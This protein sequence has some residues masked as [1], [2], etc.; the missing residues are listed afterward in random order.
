MVRFSY[1]SICKSPSWRPEEILKP[2]PIVTLS[3]F[4]LQKT[5][6]VVKH[7]MSKGSTP[8]GRREEAHGT[9]R[10]PSDWCGSNF[11]KPDFLGWTTVFLLLL[12]CCTPRK[13]K[14]LKNITLSLNCIWNSV[15]FDILWVTE[16]I[17]LPFLTPWGWLYLGQRVAKP[18]LEARH[19]DWSL[20]RHRSHGKRRPVWVGWV[21]WTPAAGP[22]QTTFRLHASTPPGPVAGPWRPADPADY[23]YTHH[24]VHGGIASKARGAVVFFF[25]F[26]R[27]ADA[28]CW[29]W[30]IR[31]FFVLVY[32]VHML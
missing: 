4:F 1:S 31:R 32:A 7:P 24:G 13:A 27:Q 6:P 22:S 20:G 8:S 19:R 21:G 11:S 30:R 12:D 18:D 3:C 26:L 25:L 23:I 10:E 9:S 15:F 2:K 29:F 28:G 16:A 5:L 17:G 14:R